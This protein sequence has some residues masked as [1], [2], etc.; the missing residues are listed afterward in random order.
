ME[1]WLAELV[2]ALRLGVLRATL[3]KVVALSKD[4]TL[5]KSDLRTGLVLILEELV[6][7]ANVVL[8]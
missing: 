3:T 2:L 4:G 5:L 6:L 7:L 1:V 8:L